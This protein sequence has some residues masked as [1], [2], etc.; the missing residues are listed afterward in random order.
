MR[1]HI[2]IRPLEPGEKEQLQQALKSPSAFTL[3]RAQYLLASHLGQKPLQIAKTYG[4]SRQNVRNVL[5]A[6]NQ[7]GIAAL[8]AKSRR[9]K[10]VR[11]LLE[12]E[13]L[14]QLEHLLHQSP[15]TF[16]KNRS[17]WTQNLLAEVAFE[18]GLTPEQVSHETIRQALLRLGAR[19]KRAKTWITSPD[20]AYARK[21]SNANA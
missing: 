17:L 16:G 12:G 3:Q 21:K 7:E 20:P 18:Q 11:P 9:P 10:S 6:F 13:S 4:G 1:A 14:E 2:Q 15:R 8:T 19:W 5:K